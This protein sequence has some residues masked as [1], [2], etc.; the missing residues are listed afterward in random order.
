MGWALLIGAVL[1]RRKRSRLHACCQSAVVLLNFGII[2]LLM[3][4]S[5]HVHVST[6]I[7]GKLG[8]DYYAV[9]TAHAALR[10]VTDIAGLYILLA[11]GTN[12]L[13]H[14]FRFAQ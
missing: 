3:L 8:K 7:P 12:I 13:P 5:L 9:A 4:P 1:P 14:R 11:A 10:G 6:K 2:V